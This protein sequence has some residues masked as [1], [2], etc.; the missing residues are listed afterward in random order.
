M[1]FERKMRVFRR[2]VQRSGVLEEVK[3]RQHYI[4]PTTRKRNALNAA[5][6]REW[7][8]MMED[9]LPTRNNRLF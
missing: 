2:K 6:R 5:K 3:N 9:T 7:R 1:N 8:R 4:K